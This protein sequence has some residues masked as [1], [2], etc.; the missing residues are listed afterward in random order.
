M[1]KNTELLHSALGTNIVFEANY[2]SKTNKLI[3]EEVIFVFIR[4][5]GM[6]RIIG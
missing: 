4:V 1:Y 6:G 2:I 5:E 3:K